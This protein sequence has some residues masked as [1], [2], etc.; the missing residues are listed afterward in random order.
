MKKRNRP[1]RIDEIIDEL[2][3]TSALGQQLEYARIWDEWPRIAGEHLSGHGRPL[4]VKDGVLHIE[5]DSPVWMHKFAYKKWHI[6]KYINRLAG[7]ELISDVFVVLG[8]ESD[9][10]PP[11]YDV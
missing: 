4:T 11:Q 10:R 6:I 3:K 5:A 2:K 9:T 8:P 1:Q 7:R